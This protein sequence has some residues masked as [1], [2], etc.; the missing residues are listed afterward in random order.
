MASAPSPPVRSNLTVGQ[1]VCVAACRNATGRQPVH[2]VSPCMNEEGVE[3]RV[4][5]AVRQR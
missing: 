3:A 2:A 4:L 5:V 1:D